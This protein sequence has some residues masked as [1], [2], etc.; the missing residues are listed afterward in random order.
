MMRM[1]KVVY[2]T[3]T[4]L[5]SVTGRVTEVRSQMTEVRKIKELQRNI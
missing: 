1:Q 2:V 3:R 4:T 5:R